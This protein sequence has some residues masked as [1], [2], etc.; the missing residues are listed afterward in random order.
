MVAL[1][2]MRP[3]APHIEAV[4]SHLPEKLFHSFFFQ[5]GLV[6]W[7]QRHREYSEAVSALRSILAPAA[8]R[9]AP[10]K[11]EID[12]LFAHLDDLCERAAETRGLTS[13][14]FR[15]LSLRDGDSE[16]RLSRA[17]DFLCSLSRGLAKACDTTAARR[18]FQFCW[19]HAATAADALPI[20]RARIRIHEA[21]VL[22]AATPVE[23]TRRLLEEGITLFEQHEG[24]VSFDADAIDAVWFYAEVAQTPEQRARAVGWLREALPS[25]RK[26]LRYGLAHACQVTE[27]L[28]RLLKE[29]GQIDEALAVCEETLRVAIRSRKL[30][31]HRV[32]VHLAPLWEQRGSMLKELGRS[33][34]AARSYS[35]CLALER[36][37]EKPAPLRLVQL[38]K[39]TGEV[40]RRAGCLGAAVSRLLEG[41]PLLDK[42]WTDEPDYAEIL[43]SLVGLPLGRVERRIEGEALLRRSIA[44]RCARLG[45]EHTE[46]ALPHRLLGVFLHEAE[47]FP[48][49]ETEFRHA[50]VLSEKDAQPDSPLPA[51]DSLA[52]L[53]EDLQRHAEALPLRQRY[54]ALAERNRRTMRH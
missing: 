44:S 4:L 38:L 31:R 23:E 1:G 19:E 25:A 43:A 36:R 14:T 10:L 47:R 12:W 20:E 17:Y 2:Q 11:A 16:A 54:L 6:G 33:L 18:L 8:E 51:L 26:L 35:H 34:A 30:R 53:L 13:F 50:L 3:Y 5:A 24:L 27:Q 7:L 45:P 46:L 41:V 9:T 52:T 22:V 21:S 15:Q 28:V 37:H 29:S 42:G 39:D 32:A 40:F 48:E 49:A